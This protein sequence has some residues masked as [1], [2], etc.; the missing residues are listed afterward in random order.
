MRKIREVLRLKYELDRTQRE[1]EASTGLSK[2]SVNDYLG[3]ASRA[4]LTW[5]IA[6]EL[7][8]AEV[9]ARLFQRIG[10]AEPPARSAIDF[11][12]VHREM[13]KKGVTLQLL[14]VE[15]QEAVAA[16]S[17]LRP[18]QYSQFCDLY[19]D[20]KGK[21]ALVMR[22][23]HRAG[24]KAFIDFS[25][26]KPVIVDPD[27][28]EV[29]EVE[30]FVMVMGA[31]NY[32][33]AEA[34]RTQGSGDFIA[35]TIRGLEYFGCVPEVLVPDQ[36]RSAVSGPDRYDP[37][38]NPAYQEMAQHYGVAI[39]PARPGK[40][41]DKAKVEVGVLIAQRWIM[42]R[43]R[44]RRFFSLDELNAAIAEL[45]EEL[46]TR[47]FIKLDG[48]R[49]SAFETIDC[50]AMR[51]L[52]ARRFE[53]GEW[54]KAKAGIDY[55]VGYLERFYSVPCALRQQPMEVRATS[56]TIEIFYHGKRIASHL[57]SYGPKGTYVTLEEHKPKSHRDY[58][59]WPPERMR[60]WAASIGPSVGAVVDC[61]LARY[62]NPEFGFRAVLA[63][64]RDAKQYGNDRLDAACA[65]AL[66]IAGPT[67]PTRHSVI[68][69][70]KRKL[71]VKPPPS[72]DE[73]TYQLPLLHENIRGAAYFDKEENRDPRR[74]DPE[75]DP[76]TPA[77]DGTGV[78]R[79]PAESA[80]P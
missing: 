80:Q 32:T 66:V 54:K 12:W 58:G 9:E 61:I 69:I 64:T 16:S 70:L 73:P 31:S 38:L 65:R 48:C 36:L 24:E 14:W 41:K 44:N 15:Y 18:Y 26:K 33:Y 22:Q 57:R 79:D 17:G 20:W 67:G 8:E 29:T 53:H 39:I 50:P 1:I 42:A 10:Q 27:T 59:N 21:L 71:E 40:A 45:L 30:L 60:S 72:V 13:R 3:R 56:S 74:N 76:A 55:H 77:H 49:R 68:A 51:P 78:P 23:T 2:G 46:N 4:G 35:A 62:R 37:E 52:P 7:S 25:G 28:G 5:E 63:L 47:K 6:S 75:T 11:E 19:A 43:L 34:T